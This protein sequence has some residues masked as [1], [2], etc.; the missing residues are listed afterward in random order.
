MGAV[1]GA[2][3]HI[4]Y[5]SSM[6]AFTIVNAGCKSL[7]HCGAGGGI[8]GSARGR[9]AMLLKRVLFAS[10]AA[11]SLIAP[12]TQAWAQYRYDDRPALNRPTQQRPVHVTQPKQAVR[13]QPAMPQP[14]P[15]E[16]ARQS[17]EHRAKPA[18]AVPLTDEQI[19]AKA[20]VDA[21]LAREP[22]LNAAKAIPDPALARA[23]AARHDAQERK[24][25]ALRAQQDAEAAR[26]RELEAKNK[27]R[28][29]AKTAAPQ[30]ET[31]RAS[32]ERQAEGGAEG[33][34]DKEQAGACD[35]FRPACAPRAGPARASHAGAGRATF[36]AQPVAIRELRQ[37]C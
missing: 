16:P 31:R 24:L 11:F 36:G 22:A 14:K 12:V 1:G 35:R 13:P 2:L 8:G 20:A 37:R 18:P 17:V 30:G 32:Q 27:A 4:W 10:S 7:E 21:L 29:E 6:A 34:A 9:I 28:E 5:M 26:R 33:R 3:N 19:A 25:A 23:A 15:A